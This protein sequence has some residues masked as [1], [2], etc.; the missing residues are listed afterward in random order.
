MAYEIMQQRYRRATEALHKQGIDAWISMGRETTILGEPALEL[1]LPF[2]IMGRTVVAITAMGERICIVA[3][4]EAEEIEESGIFTQVRLYRNLD[5]FRIEL[6]QLI[7][8]FAAY[9]KIALNV[10]ESDPSADGLSVSD[11][12]LLIHMMVEANAIGE[13]VSSAELMKMIRG[14]K[15][16]EEVTLI[17]RTVQAAM[18]LYDDLRPQIRIG[19]SGREVQALFQQ[20]IDARGYGYSWQKEGNPYISVG[21]RSSYLCKRPPEEV[22]LQ[23]GDVINIDL[24]LR[25][26]GYAS[27]NQRTLYCL[28][29]GETEAPEE[30]QHAFHT[31]QAINAAV[32][33]AMRSGVSSDDLTAI[34][35]E[36]MLQQG[37]SQGWKGSFGH[38]LFYY[39]H[40]G[41]IKT[42]FTPYMPELDKTLE[43]NMTFTL[44][45]SI[46]TAYGRVC[47][48]EVVC[49][50]ASG[51]RMLS[52][53]Q[54]EI[55]LIFAAK[56]E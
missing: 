19:M 36:I 56:E 2:Q 3:P 28:K 45:P 48:E 47:Q 50:T 4:M 15:S 51:G 10:S 34:G 7:K 17:A 14:S 35:N 49:V 13:F 23:P 44:E 22:T 43:E 52:T 46:I 33:T 55:W 18:V 29:P 31:L 27:D 20:T 8:E 41:G 25:I 53:P 42:G 39:A 9:D 5:E 38:E 54:R 21:T 26:D 1:L 32:C 6:G 24:G 12:K 40:H 11:H 30:V 16:D 37:F